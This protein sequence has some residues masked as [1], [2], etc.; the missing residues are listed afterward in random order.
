[1]QIILPRTDLLYSTVLEYSI[2]KYAKVSY[3]R[4]LVSSRLVYSCFMRTD[5]TCTCHGNASKHFNAKGR[6]GKRGGKKQNGKGRK[7]EKARVMVKS[8]WYNID[9]RLDLRFGIPM[10]E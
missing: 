4:G 6:E 3:E 9:E 2:L 10:N 8:P 7:D 1:M 5:D